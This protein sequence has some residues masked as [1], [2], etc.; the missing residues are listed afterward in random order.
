MPWVIVEAD[1]A[2][3]RLPSQCLNRLQ[4]EDNLALRGELIKKVLADKPMED[5]LSL[6]PDSA[7][8]LTAL[9]S[10]GQD[11]LASSLRRWQAEQAVRLKH[12]T[13]QLSASQLEVVEE[14]IERVGQGVDVAASGNPN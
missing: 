10:I 1:D 2:D 4:G 8:S 13:A 9:A 7:E 12:F 5:V 11:D 3:A 6:L 14:A